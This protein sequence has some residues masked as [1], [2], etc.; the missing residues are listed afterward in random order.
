M[1]PIEYHDTLNTQRQR[2]LGKLIHDR[3]TVEALSASAK[4]IQEHQH[5]MRTL[6]EIEGDIE[7]VKSRHW[8]P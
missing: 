8:R 2:V 6:Q 5:W 7:R 3:M 4:T 1:I